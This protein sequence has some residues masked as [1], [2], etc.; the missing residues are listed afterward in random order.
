[1]RALDRAEAINVVSAEGAKAHNFR[2]MA[3]GYAVSRGTIQYRICDYISRASTGFDG[4]FAAGEAI[5]RTMR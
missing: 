1:M 3:N 5:R 4:D 2:S